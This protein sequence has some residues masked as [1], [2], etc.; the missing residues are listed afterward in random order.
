MSDFTIH[1]SETADSMLAKDFERTRNMLGYIPNVFGVLAESPQCLKG[2]QQL[3]GLV[4]QSSLSAV[5]RNIVWLVASFE[6]NCHYCMAGHSALAGSQGTPEVIINA[7]REDKEL[8]DQ[9]LQALRV[10]AREV[11]R[12]RGEVDEKTVLSLKKQGYTNRTILDV[13][14]AVA[15]KT[16]TNYANHFADTPVDTAYEKFTWSHPDRK[17]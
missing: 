15:Q 4:M 17:A 7:I 8:T 10:F 1:T 6:N 11:V 12:N 13:I 2:Y 5:E 9:K 14:L 16:I 3:M